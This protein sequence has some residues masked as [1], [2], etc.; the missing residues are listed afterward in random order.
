V[1]DDL[2]AHFFEG[3]LPAYRAFVDSLRSDTAGQNS[4]LRL[5]KDAALALFHLRE[6]VP[7]AKGKTWPVFLSACPEYVLLQDVVNVF[8]HGPRREGQ[9]ARPTDIYEIIV[10]T[11]YEDAEGPYQHA[12]KEVAIQLR[13]GTVRDMKVVLRT[14]LDMWIAEFKSRGSLSRLE[15]RKPETRVIPT[16]A[17]ASGASRIN[18]TM[19]QGLRATFQFR[20]QKF[21]HATGQI[22]PIDITGHE[23]QLSI[24]KPIEVDIVMKNNETGQKIEDT[25]ELSAEETMHYRTLKTEEERRA[26]EATL[27]PKYGRRLLARLSHNTPTTSDD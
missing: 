12:E 2:E 19:Q 16:R 3:V 23:Y 17:A 6:H 14:V 8:K 21:N 9:V 13:D 27:A 22:E 20:R 10:M 4:D 18:F 11:E 15:P 5:G 26:Y 7:W 1:F 25:V 24:Y